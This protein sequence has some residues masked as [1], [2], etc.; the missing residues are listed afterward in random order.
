MKRK[1]RSL[2]HP[3][4]TLSIFISL[5]SCVNIRKATYFNGQEDAV[6][7]A[8]ETAVESVIQKNDLLDIS[9]TSLNPA[10]SA[11]FNASN[12]YHNTTDYANANAQQSTGY[13][14]RGDGNIHFPILGKIRAEGL[15]IQNLRDTITSQLLDRKLLIEPIVNVRYLNFRVTV[16]GEVSKPSVINISNEKI[17]LLEALGLAGDITVF[18]KRDNIMLIREE[19]NSRV[20]KRLDLNSTAFL[21]SPYYYLKSND[22]I[23]VQP[24]KTKIASSGRTMQLLPIILSALSFTAIILNRIIP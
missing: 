20:V 5:S 1:F 7:T 22:I 15:T 24:N 16:L 10:A 11:L 23:Y 14:V 17:T 18:G 6:L 13:L 9:V 2:I 21:T 3:L 4:L 12:L 8:S 19:H